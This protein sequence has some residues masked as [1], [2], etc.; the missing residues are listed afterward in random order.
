M[1]TAAKVSEFKDEVEVE[2]SVQ[3]T[4]ALNCSKEPRC[5]TKREKRIADSSADEM[6]NGIVSWKIVHNIR[7]AASRTYHSIQNKPRPCYIINEIHSSLIYNSTRNIRNQTL[8]KAFLLGSGWLSIA[9]FR[10]FLAWSWT[11]FW[12]IDLLKKVQSLNLEEW[13]FLV[14]WLTHFHCFY[15]RWNS[16]VK[17]GLLQNVLWSLL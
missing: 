8:S 6:E 14:R 17:N 15:W 3:D 1:F 10:V 2:A 16:L 5:S 7:T 13:V 11:H 12:T 9:A 4:K